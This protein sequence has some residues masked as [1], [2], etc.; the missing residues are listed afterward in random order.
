MSKRLK[1]YKKCLDKYKQRFYTVIDFK[2]YLNIKIIFNENFK[3]AES[4]EFKIEI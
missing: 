3:I 1:K 4:R 2:D